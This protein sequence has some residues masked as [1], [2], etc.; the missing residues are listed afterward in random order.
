[1]KSFISRILPLFLFL[2]TGDGKYYVRWA[3]LKA[4]R[5]IF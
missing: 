5:T 2:V 4:R 1:M 3:V